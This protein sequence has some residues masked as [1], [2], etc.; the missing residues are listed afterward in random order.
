MHP[1]S[2]HSAPT[3]QVSL[4]EVLAALS[5]ALDLT[6][7]QP[8][9]HS[10]RTCLIG[11]RMA[12]DIGLSPE[13]RSAL[14]YAL[15]LKDAGCSSNAARMA[16]LFGSDDQYV[17][18]RM[19]VV[20]WH[21]RFSLALHTARNVG[22]GRGISERVRHFVAI[23][24][25][26]GMTRDLIAVRCE[27]GAAIARQLGFPESTAQ[28]IRSLDEHWCGLGYPEGLA[29]DRIPLLARI[30][31]IAQAVEAFHDT[32]GV[33][34]ALEVV[35]ERRGSWFD[36]ELVDVVLRWEDD[37]EWWR[38]LRSANVR[39]QVVVA[40]PADQVRLAD[41][42]ELNGVA[43]AFADIID[44]K[45]PYTYCHSSRVAEYARTL[46]G[47]LGLDADEQRRIYRA[48]LLHDIGKLGV[49]N[50][51][52]DKAGPL[53]PAEWQQVQQHPKYTLS[54]LSQVSAFGDFAWT[55]ALHHEKLDGSGYSWG[56]R[57]KQL[58]LASRIL[59]VVD[60]YDAVTT[61]RPYR[62]GMD[63][64]SAMQLLVA[65]RETK[66]CERVVDAAHTLGT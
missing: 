51:I 27:R 55:A 4:S 20:D 29:E 10:I 18:P 42:D 64:P 56:L 61:D 39:E 15:L 34:A 48:G 26:E 45:S 13:D 47:A 65:D 6:E 9:G 54:I 3:A 46:A 12:S 38:G 31:N 24:R 63:H 50:R 5:H 28:A 8:L 14:Y 41:D 49:S 30:A 52:L 11:M 60:I 43:R 35:R 19:K 25:T 62:G 2:E 7:G 58:D 22:A 32:G 33:S 21:H 40:E 17:K 59:A 36:P 37:S 66:L 23:A 57:A 16:A 1:A 44:A 53:T